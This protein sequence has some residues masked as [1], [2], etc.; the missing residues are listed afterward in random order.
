[1]RKSFTVL[2]VAVSS[3]LLLSAC[4]TTNTA[5]DRPLTPAEQRQR[6]QADVYNQTLLEG[7]G[8]GCL[9]GAALGAGIGAATSHKNKG[10][11]TLVDAGIGCL[12]GGLIGGVAGDYVASKQQQYADKE[13]QLDSMIADVRT[14]NQ[15]LAGL[16]TTTQ[17]VIADDKVRMDQIDQELASGKITMAQ[18][19]QKMAAVDDNRA[20]LDNTLSKLRERKTTYAEAAKK[21]A[22]G[23]SKA[24]TDAM[25]AEIATLEKQ[26][27]QL[28]AERNSLVQRRTVSR[29]G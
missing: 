8:V 28:E 6:Q 2:A 16:I 24:K 9:G 7:I 13:Q 26:I 27:A 25:N 18:A 5:S 22:P 20:Y 4:Q 1:M 3:S 17:Q 12:V 19:K 11:N 14:E 10:R 23:A 21:T 15:R 29:V